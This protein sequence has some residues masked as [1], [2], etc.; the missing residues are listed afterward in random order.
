MNGVKAYPHRV[1]DIGFSSP[2]TLASVRVFPSA[3]RRKVVTSVQIS[4]S[5]VSLAAIAISPGDFIVT[6]SIGPPDS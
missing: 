4:P 6:A 1:R 3:D 2:G 5:P